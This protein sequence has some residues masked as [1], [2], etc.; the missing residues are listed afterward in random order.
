MLGELCW[1]WIFLIDQI[2]SPRNRQLFYALSQ[3]FWDPVDPMNHIDKLKGRSV[4]WQEAIGDEQVPN[5][6]TRMLAR[7]VDAVHL[8]PVVEPVPGLDSSLGPITGPALVQFDPETERPVEAN[9]PGTPSGAHSHVRTWPGC[10][11]Q[12]AHFNDWYTPGEVVHF[13]GEAPCTA[14]NPGL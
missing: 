6:T 4:L 14:S 1:R 8:E 10:R 11:Q 13:C 2:P 7:A 9:T 12:I 5:M 3:L